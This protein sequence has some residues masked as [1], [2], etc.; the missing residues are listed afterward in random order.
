MLP[1][2]KWYVNRIDKEIPDD[3]PRLELIRR[4][5]QGSSDNPNPSIISVHRGIRRYLRTDIFTAHHLFMQVKYREKIKEIEQKEKQKAKKEARYRMQAMKD[6]RWG[7]QLADEAMRQKCLESA[8]KA[9]A[10]YAKREIKM[11]EKAAEKRAK[12]MRKNVKVA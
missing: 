1:S 8:K 3:S 7:A 2:K 10:Q 11:A 9:Y 12:A 4:L 6:Q 5:M